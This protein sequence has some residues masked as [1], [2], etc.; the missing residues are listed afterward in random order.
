MTRINQLRPEFV[1]YIPET[2][3]S[4]V[5]YIS[6]R[7]RTASHLCCSGCGLV[8]VTPLNAAKWRIT[9]HGAG[10]VSLTPSVGNWS[11]PCRSHYWIDH[12]EV[13]WAGSFSEA[14]IAAVKARDRTDSVRLYGRSPGQ[15]L[16]AA[17]RGI[18][19][20]F[21]RFWSH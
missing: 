19:D 6:K 21:H 1:D 13:R 5:L 8:V 7:Y 3:D 9:E 15:R 4:G 2:L 16:A 20:W 17:L 18:A 12:N 14:R 10:T 11:F